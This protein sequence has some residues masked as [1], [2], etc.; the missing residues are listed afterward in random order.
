MHSRPAGTAVPRADACAFNSSRPAAWKFRRRAAAAL[1]L[2]CVAAALPDRSDAQTVPAKPSGFTTEDGNTQVRL[3]WTGPNDRTITAWQYSYGSVPGSSEETVAFSDWTNMAGSGPLTRRYSVAGLTNN[4]AYKFKIRA[5]NAVGPGPESDEQTAEPYPAAPDKP[6]NFRAIAGHERILL[7]WSDADDV[8][9]Q[10]WEYRQKTA[11]GTAGSWLRMPGSNSGTTAYSVTGLENGIEYSFWVR[12][13]NRAGNGYPSDEKTATPRPAAPAKPTGFS[14]E[15]GHRKVTLSWN[16]PGNDTI[17]GWQYT[18]KTAG[19]FHDWIDMAGSGAATVR[20]VVSMLENDTRYTFKLR[21]VNNIGNGAESDEISATPTARAPGKPDGFTAHAGDGKIALSWT[22]PFDA[23]ISN[24]QYAYRTV[25]SYG[26]WN[27]MPGSSAA[28]TSYTVD[29]L[30]N[31]T[32]YVVKIRA[33]NDVG[34]GPESDEAS[35]V[36]LSVPA[37]P[38]GFTARAGDARVDLGWNDPMNAAITVWQYSFRTVGEYGGWTD[39]PNSNAATTGY[40]VT[41]LAN[42]VAHTFRLRAV[43]DSGYSA[44][45]EAASVTPRP[46]PAKPSGFRA[47]AGNT[48]V[49]LVWTDPGNESIAGWQYGLKTT[50]NYDGWTAIPGSGAGTTRHTVTALTN[51]TAYTFRLRATNPSGAG[52]ESDEV[53]ATPRAAPPARPTGFKAEAG[54]RQVVLSWDDPDDSSIEAWQYKSRESDGAYRPEWKTVVGSSARTVQ[55]IVT[56]L[57]NGKI[58]IFKI[59]GVNSTNGYESD[60]RSATPRSLRPAA[61][62]GLNAA[63]GDGRVAL[64]WDDPGDATITGWQYAVRSAGTFGDW[65]DIPGSTTSTTGY[66]VSGLDN[67]T[68]HTFKL[69]AV[70]DKGAG[71]ES[72]EVS[73]TPLS[74]PDKP[75]GLTATPG[76][77]WVL[78]EWDGPGDPDISGWQYNQRRAGGDFAESWTHVP[79]SSAATTSYRVNGLAIGASYGFKI[80]AEAGERTGT[81]SEEATATLPPLPTRPQGLTAIAG[82]GEVLLRWTALGNPTVTHWQ[83]SCGTPDGPAVWIDIPRSGAATADYRV[84][85]LDNGATHDFRIRAVNSSGPGPASNLVSAVPL[86]APPKPSGFTAAPGDGTVLLEWDA[87]EDP[88]VTGWEYNLRRFDESFAEDWTHIF[89]SGSA[90]SRHAIVD[91]ENG[92]SYAF[93]LRAVAGGRIGRESDEASARPVEGLPPAPGNLRAIPGHRQATLLWDELHNPAITDWQ[94]R[95]RTTGAFGGWNEIPGAGHSLTDYTATDLTNGVVHRFQVRAGTDAGFGLPSETA[96]VTPEAPKPWRPTGLT[97]S[98]GNG[99]VVL[100]W[101]AV[102]DAALHWE[103]AQWVDDTGM[104]AH[105]TVKWSDI[106]SADAGRHTVGGLA[107][108]VSYCFQVRICTNGNRASCGPGSVPVS[109]TPITAAKPVERKAVSAVLAGLATRVAAAAEAVIG[110]RF[111][112]DTATPTLVLG[113]H[114]VPLSASLPEPELPAPGGAAAETTDIG[115]DVRDLL[116]STEFNVSLGPPAGDGFL[117]WSLWHRGDFRAFQGAP[118]PELRYGGRMLSAWFGIDMRWN[119]VWLAG[120]AMAHSKGEVEYAAGADSG[121][122]K[123]TLESVHPYLQRRF[124]DGGSVWMMIGGGRGTVENTTADRSVEAADTRLAT[125][126]AGFRRPLPALRGLEL[127]ASGAAGLARL[128]AEGAARTAFDSLSVSSDRQSLGLKAALEEGQTSRYMSMALRRDGGDGLTGA[129]LELASGFRSPLPRSSGHVD[130]QARW[131]ARHSEREY[132]EFGLTATVRRPAGAGSDGLSWSL[133][134]AYGARRGGNGGPGPLWSEGMGERSGIESPPALDFRTGW[135]F[136]FHGGVYA[137]HAALGVAGADA[138]AGRMAVGLD[139]GPVS[140][141]VL[142]LAAERC[143]RRAGAPEDRI[144]ADLAF[145]F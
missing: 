29:G 108:G 51:D 143:I 3:R 2:T 54:D 91:L 16:N 10:G 75:S 25:G 72:G 104:C 106:G 138:D 103:Y 77:G 58:Y 112:A 99:Q 27:D 97:A 26:Q 118:G 144:T 88:A 142:K 87:V 98:P 82:D 52:A 20:H 100:T 14:A 8:S 136:V 76:S 15:P 130:I 145:R 43:N 131:L 47:E 113:G 42:G 11:G 34:H 101:D 6:E 4:R 19:E 59:R 128:R 141:P 7:Q 44:E 107:N 81:A 85:G 40:T 53:S 69:R 121:V 50:G 32:T 70:N 135:R 117:K 9:I 73:A 125:V 74:I 116:R 39:I 110:P 62:T 60:E 102:D 119:R 137:P 33:A 55:H 30:T 37:R 114:R 105:G 23:S 18:Y 123:S 109:A 57:E 90:M 124:D 56:G 12:A 64:T 93:K 127:S 13:Y 49:R 139:L 86:A 46:V 67:G 71:E 31:G 22:D 95:Y 78:L 132:R 134:A 133:A 63:A 36:P 1:L 65:T 84:S 48:Q 140:G 92:V 28:T 21:T 61:P 35:A 122:V 115:M 80:R 120:A 129:G 79:G 45:S 41:G 111:S 66:A 68:E 89:G 126:S 24:W 83:C 94:Y 5:V 96:A 38:T 17:T